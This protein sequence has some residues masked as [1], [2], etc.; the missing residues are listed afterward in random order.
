VGVRAFVVALAAAAVFVPSAAAARPGNDNRADAQPVSPPTQVEG[1]TAGSTLE[2]LDPADCGKLDGT[3]WYGLLVPG[4]GRFVVRLQAGGNLDASVAVYRQVRSRLDRVGCDMTD[5]KGRAAT[6]FQAEGGGTYLVMVGQRLNSEPGTFKLT[7]FQA[8]PPATPPGKPLP[9]A[10]VRS[11]VDRLGKTDEAWSVQM[12]AGTSYRINLVSFSGACLG[13]T[14]FAS[15]NTSFDDPDGSDYCEGYSTFTPGPDGGGRYSI[16]ITADDNGD[17]TPQRYRLQVAQAQADDIGPGVPIRN[18]ETRRGRLSGLGIDGVDLYRFDVVRTSDVTLALHTGPKAQFDL[19]VRTDTGRRVRC[20]CDQTGGAK[21]RKTLAPGRYS[22]AVRTQGHSGGRYRLS[23][24]IR[25]ITSTDVLA[26]G[27]HDSTVSPGSPVPITASVSGGQ[28]GGF[29]E[30]QIDRLDPLSGWEFL[31][32]YRVPVSGG[33]ASVSWT[34]PAVGHYRVRATFL[35]T[36]TES[37]SRS[38]Y[39]NL[40]VAAPLGQ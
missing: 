23:L 5:D 2:K 33:G 26:A 36:G 18:T 32:L 34:P 35:G 30:V 10:G 14:L 29:V 11:Q 8:Q 27:S 15:G 13:L 22:V 17:F 25:G 39:A 20:I 3:V 16:L 7:V 6:S 31:R 40:L 37:P 9:A 1:T 24:L 28:T 12:Q 38:R 19:D 21:F 4:S